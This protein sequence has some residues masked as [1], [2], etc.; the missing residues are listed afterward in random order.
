MTDD[1]SLTRLL[2]ERVMGWEK[3]QEYPEHGIVRYQDA[4][5][6]QIYVGD[7][8]GSPWRPLED[9]DDAWMVVT[10]VGNLG[11]EYQMGGC[12]EG[13]FCL[14][15]NHERRD[16]TPWPDYRSATDEAPQRA[17]AL[18]ALKVVEVPDA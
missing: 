17:I 11:W 7:K 1:A 2:A 15:T 16:D 8:A 6:K 14:F 3:K 13:H 18:A 10:R 12:P 9:M 5:G 4:D